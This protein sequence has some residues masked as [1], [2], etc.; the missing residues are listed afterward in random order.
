MDDDVDDLAFIREAIKNHSTPFTVVE[1]KNGEEGIAWL[2]HAKTIG[3][4]PCLIIMDI[5]MPKMDGRRAIQII[6]EDKEI[7]R[8]PLVVFTTSS[9]TLDKRYFELYQ[10]EYITKPNQY[11]AFTN[12]VYEMLS[13]VTA[14]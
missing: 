8:I 13:H 3:V 1:A 5:N 14:G 11:Q 9:S 4:L 2:S 12:K 6:K 7:S 10:V